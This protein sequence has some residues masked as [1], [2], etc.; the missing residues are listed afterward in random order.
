MKS[1]L[2]FIILVTS[3]VSINLNI[4]TFSPLSNDIVDFVNTFGSTWTAEESKFLSW[5][6][7]S[8]KKLLGVPLDH[9]KRP[10]ILPIIMSS[11]RHNRNLPGK[12]IN[13]CYQINYSI[14]LLN[15]KESFDS[16]LQW[17]NC[18]TIQEVRDQGSC[19]SCWAFGAVEAISDR[20]CIASNGQ[21]IVHISAQNLC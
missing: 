21:T 13:L 17:P 3:V 15:F 19:G 18:P 12:I 1:F 8:F 6:L 5:P 7:E 16:R 9:F 2:I 10:K 4:K 14:N 11:N 20:I